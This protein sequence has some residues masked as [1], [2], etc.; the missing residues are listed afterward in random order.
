MFCSPLSAAFW[1]AAGYPALHMGA[2]RA[3]RGSAAAG[4]GAIDAAGAGLSAIFPGSLEAPAIARYSAE[5]LDCPLLGPAVLLVTEVSGEPARLVGRFERNLPDPSDGRRAFRRGSGGGPLLLGPGRLYLN[6]RLATPAA[7]TACDASKL[8]NRYVRPLLRALTKVTAP[9]HY[10]GRDWISCGGAPIASIA[11]A[12]HARSGRA[13]IESVVAFSEPFTT[14]GKGAPSF[15]GKT[16]TTI[17]KVSTKTRNV[18]DLCAS[19]AQ[20]YADAYGLALVHRP[21]P[22]FPAAAPLAVEPPWDATLPEAIG[23]I[24]ASVDNGHLRL[25]GAFMASEDAVREFEGR[26]SALPSTATVD[27]VGAD[28]DAVFAGAGDVQ[29]AHIALFGVRSLASI[30]DVAFAALEKSRRA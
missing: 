1:V 9:T 20:A 22:P 23:D 3:D 12:H 29:N 10:F 8:L 30:R 6:L 4:G 17:E 26:V 14:L 15:L 18:S 21:L 28:A 16:P 24:G 13:M 2:D 7:L 5:S 27:D 25:G 19:L 11:F